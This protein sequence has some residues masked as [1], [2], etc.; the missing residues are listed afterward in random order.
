MRRTFALGIRLCFAFT[1]VALCE[2]PFK[3]DPFVQGMS[4]LRANDVEKA[5]RLL[6]SVP[7]TDSHFARAMITVGYQLYGRTLRRPEMG[8]PY[9]ERA[10]AKAHD[11]ME[12]VKAYI[13]V[14]VLSGKAFPTERPEREHAKKVKPE[15]ERLTRSFKSLIE[16][17][18]LSRTKLEEDL[19]FLELRLK[20]CYSYLRRH[21][22][23]YE[24]ALDAVRTSLRDETPL[25]EF[26]LRV[27]ML[28]CLFGD[29]HSRL[30]F[31]VPSL[32]ARGYA[33]FQAAPRGKRF[34]AF[35]TDRRSFIDPGCP[36]LVRIDGVEVARWLEAADPIIPR[37]SPQLV[38][39]QRLQMLILLN[40][41]RQELDLPLKQD[42]QLE[43]ESEDGARR[44]SVSLRVENEP[45]ERAPIS[46]RDTGR[47]GEFGYLLVERMAM[48]SGFLDGLNDRME[49]LKGTKGLIIDVRDNGGGTQ[50]ALKT[51]L[52]YFLGPQDP[53]QIVNV[54][55]YRLPVKLPRPNPA[56]FLGL[57]GRSLHPAT[58]KVWKAEE[59]ER[60][61]DLLRSFKPS[62]ALPPEEFSDWH[63]MAVH[64][65][66]NP[67][68]YGYDRPVCVLSNEGSF[69]ATD[70]FLGAF[71][72]R[73]NVTIVGT[74]SGGGSGRMQDYEMPNSRLRF[75]LSQ[76]ASY[77]R[78]GQ[79]YDGHGVHPDALV[80]AAP[81]DHIGKGDAVLDAALKIL[82]ERVKG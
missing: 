22:V 42:V 55:A 11:D 68:A 8:V 7:E 58:S 60:I 14:L 5:I 49:E 18:G 81:E 32:L 51:L 33:P 13:D 4:A 53:L 1:A 23:D 40:H 35:T 27:H 37:A 75:T 74:P 62:W 65:K 21:G 63:V 6:G 71:Q 2:D 39:G 57:H 50:D 3:D 24:A 10:Y 61:R 38:A 17:P 76:M 9:V 48:D 70:N 25:A 44:K 82:R 73:P 54:A 59:A 72:G 45:S 36:F 19:D 41:L 56:G 31:G 78:T 30:S 20:H 46:R 12:V 69:S 79:L 28:L 77:S 34:I 16:S 52:P 26:A 67:R 43:L 80:E 47:I 64:P 66:S 15:F 29:M